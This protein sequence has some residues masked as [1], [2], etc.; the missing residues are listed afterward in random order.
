MSAYV[1][2]KTV[3][4]DLE[5]LVKALQ[6][7]GFTVEIGKLTITGYQDAKR[8][9]DIAIR[10]DGTRSQ[11]GD[12]GYMKEADGTYTLVADDYD[13]TP[14][15]GDF[16]CIGPKIQNRVKARYSYHQVTRLARQRGYAVVSEKTANGRTKLVMR[17]H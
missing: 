15:H 3:F 9:V 16:G 1:V 17:R 12:F 2:C 4:R 13:S 11:L 10:R 6:D 14:G 8:E 7:V 5:S